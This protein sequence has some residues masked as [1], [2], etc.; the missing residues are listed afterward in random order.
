MAPSLRKRTS[1]LV[2]CTLTST[3]LGSTRR[4]S[5]ASGNRT[6]SRSPRYACST[7][8]ARLRWWM[9]RPL[10]RITMCSRLARCNAG[11]LIRPV[12]I[13]S[14][15]ASMAAAVG[16][17]YTA[18]KAAR[19]SPVPAVSSTRRP[20]APSVI[21]TVGCAS[22]SSLPSRTMTAVSVAGCLRNLRRA[23]V[24]KNSRLTL[25]RVPT[26]LP[27]G[28]API[29][30]PPS[31]S[32]RY[33]SPLSRGRLT[34]STRATAA[35]LA[36]A[37]PRNPRVRIVRR[38]SSERILLVACRKN[39]SGRSTGA[40]PSPSSTT[41]IR[42]C[43]AASMRTWI[44]DAPASIAFS[45]SSLTTAA[46]RS[47]TSPAAIPSATAAGRIVMR[48]GSRPVSVRDMLS[49]PRVELF[50]RLARRQALQVELLELGDH[51]V[52]QRQ[53]ELRAR[54]RM[55]QRPLSLQVGKDLTRS[56]D[57]LARKAGKLRDMNAVAAVG[58]PRHDLMQED[59]T[60]AFFAD[61]HP[62]VAQPRQPLGQRGQLVV[63]SCEQRQRAQLWSIVQVLQDRLGDADAVVGAGAA[64]D[65][66]EDEQAAGG[67]VREDV[68][69]LHHLDH[70][71]RQAAGQLVVRADPREDPVAQPDDG[72][73]GRNEAAHLGEQHDDA[74]LA[75][76]R[77]LA[78][79]VRAAQEHNLLIARVQP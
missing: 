48:A 25:T 38:S 26:G 29:C 52:I 46:G 7:A 74:G 35:M 30:A 67:R 36:S 19:R 10:R 76:V 12:T 8:K 63:M 75:K 77:R 69:G 2:G 6:G 55:F 34:A 1:R 3:S 79:H 64:A 66:I 16:A 51:R 47:T 61:F 42:P 70:E 4:S 20:S 17:S 27:A 62:E 37:S 33:P 5:T 15:T 53:T 50:Q 13:P 65:L 22:A 68:S 44:R 54:A 60:L 73:A 78:C 32:T 24:L 49:L 71:G 11:G 14:S 57:H 72:T 39:A 40:I 58:A 56:H 28:P 43:P 23:G 41:S 21:A 18:A 59:D 31:T 9:R 45:T